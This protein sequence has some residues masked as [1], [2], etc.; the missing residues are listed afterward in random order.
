MQAGT[1]V[2]LYGTDAHGRVL[3]GMTGSIVTVG[4]LYA[5]VAV[6]CWAGEVVRVLRADLA[7]LDATPRS[8]AAWR[9]E[10]FSW[11]AR[12]R[13]VIKRMWARRDERGAA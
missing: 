7:P 13:R 1:Q 11:Q 8:V 6:R 2:R 4:A 5:D 10:H 12:N 9:A 3:D